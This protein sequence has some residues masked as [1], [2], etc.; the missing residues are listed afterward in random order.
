MDGATTDTWGNGPAADAAP[1]WGSG[2]AN[3][4]GG[5]HTDVNGGGDGASSEA[6]KLSK[7][8]YSKKARDAGWT[9]ATAFNYDEF[10]RTGGNDADWYGAAKVYEWSDEFGDV[11]PAVPELEKILFGGEFQMRRGEHTEHLEL[12]VNI[13]SPEKVSPIRNVSFRSDLRSLS[14]TNT[15]QSSKM[16]GFT[17]WSWRTL[18]SP[19][20][21]AQLPSKPTRSRLSCRATMSSLLRRQVSHLIHLADPKNSLTLL[22]GSG[23]TAAY[24]IPVV[25]K[26]MGKI[27]KLGAAR[28]N[29]TAADFDLRLHK[30]KAEPLVV[31]VVPT[32][33]LAMQIFDEAR[34]MCYRSMLRPC[35]AYGGLPMGITLDELGKGC[36]VLIATPGRL[37]DLMDKP[38]ILTMSRVK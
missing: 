23:K 24:M 5:E 8:E 9:E 2:D 13:E 37:C 26:L 25:S 35:V 21:S 31:V 1:A 22:S 7:E 32:R 10:Q 29:T 14:F 11:A 28:P 38:H 30:V 34:R 4:N 18:S 6:K 15:S 19:S 33:E 12:T 17:Q 3:A 16:P 20:M 36:D 27:K